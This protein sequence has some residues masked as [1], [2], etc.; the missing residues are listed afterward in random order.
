MIVS[1]MTP[2]GLNYRMPVE[3]L[4]KMSHQF[5][6]NRYHGQNQRM[7]STVLVTCAGNLDPLVI[8]QA[9]DVKHSVV[10][11]EVAFDVHVTSIDDARERLKALIG[12]VDKPRHQ[13]G[14]LR[15][16]HKPDK[17]PPAGCRAEPTI[18]FEDRKSGVRLKCYIRQEKVAAGKFGGL[19]LRLEWTLKASAITRHLGGNQ[20]KH[21]I[22]A[23]LNA[24]LV[25]NLRLQSVDHVAVGKLFRVVKG[26]TAK[27]IK[28]RPPS[29]ARSKLDQWNARWNDPDS[30]AKRAAFLVLRVLCYREHDRGT[31]PSEECGP[32]E[33][34]L[35]VSY[36]SEWAFEVCKNSPAQVRGYLRRLRPGKRPVRRGRPMTMP[37]TVR[38]PITDH[39][40][41]A[42][43]RP[44]KLQ[45]VHRYNHRHASQI[46]GQNTANINHLRSLNPTK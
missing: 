43:L 4:R 17:E 12:L 20:I 44:V 2:G 45:P 7:K 8:L 28:T 40:I 9:H 41:D 19:I 38:R 23:D 35:E 29:G 21:L 42:C 6:I 37:L 31:F 36:P 24:F 46:T 30:R 15:I 1:S 22:A 16:E 34:G 33:D 26:T 10:E 18:Y 39:R 3:R 14:R 11:A 32:D 13:R 27:S 25:K 5:C